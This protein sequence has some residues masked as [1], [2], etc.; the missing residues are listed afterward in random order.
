MES[1]RAAVSVYYCR[2]MA[3]A[4]LDLCH[5]LRSVARLSF[6]REGLRNPSS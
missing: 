3:T 6:D 1:E 5:A 2:S 4:E